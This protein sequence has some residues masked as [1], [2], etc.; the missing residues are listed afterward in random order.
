MD[1][2]PYSETPKLPDL[3]K[4]NS[5]PRK[6]VFK[7]SQSGEKLYCMPR[8][9]VSIGGLGDYLEMPITNASTTAIKSSLIC[10]QCCVGEEP[11]TKESCQQDGYSN[12]KQGNSCGCK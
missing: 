12:F 11:H 2:L 8:D 1:R 4:K 7:Y 10:Y 9:L 3:T 5:K 6:T